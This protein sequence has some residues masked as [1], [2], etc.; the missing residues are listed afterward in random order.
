MNLKREE[1]R[2]GGRQGGRKGEGE[3]ERENEPQAYLIFTALN[4][5]TWFEFSFTF[6]YASF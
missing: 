6:L 2:E 3:K 4:S 5:Y 1:G